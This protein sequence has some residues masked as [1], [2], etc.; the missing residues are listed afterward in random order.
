MNKRMEEATLN[1]LGDWFV[2]NRIGA[3]LGINFNTYLKHP[4]YYDDLVEALNCGHG[5]HLSEAGN[6]V[7]VE[8]GR[9]N[10]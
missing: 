2:A 10:G 5:L 8:I 9:A 6:L 7:A 1:T 3:L 4:D